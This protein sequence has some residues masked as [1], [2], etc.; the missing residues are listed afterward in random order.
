MMWTSSHFLSL[1]QRLV[2]ISSLTFEVRLDEGD[3]SGVACP[4]PN[5]RLPITED[6]LKRIFGSDSPATWRQRWG[7][8]GKNT[9]KHVSDFCGVLLG[10]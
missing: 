8:K 6:I 4:E 10:Q 1:G 9:N 3:V 2:T 5:C 7:V